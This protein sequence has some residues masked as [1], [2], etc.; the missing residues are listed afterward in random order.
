MIKTV[1]GTIAILL[2]LVATLIACTS[3][4]T[5]T[6][7]EISTPTP[8]P[9]PKP[10]EA[11]SNL[12]A[13]PSTN[14]VNLYWDDN[15]NDEQGFR[16]YRDGSLISTLLS[17]TTTYQ[18]VGL[19]P[20][21]TYQYRVTAFNQTGESGTGIL[22]VRTPNPPITVK[23]DRIGVHDNGEEF[24]RDI[25]GG[26][27]YIGII[28]TDGSK[29]I[30]TRLPTQE[31]QFFNLY[32]D[33]IKDIGTILFSTNEVGDYLRIAAVGYESDGGP[34]E[35]LIYQ[36]LGTAAESYLT[37]GATS[38]LGLDL[39]LGNIIGTLFGAEDDW[40]GSFEKAWD[41]NSDWGIGSYTDVS[42]QMKDGTIGLRFWFTID[43]R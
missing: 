10:P 33:D 18:D 23:I 31:G 28:I 13:T 15:S 25:D 8:A 2:V 42:C 43:S 11:P 22:S 38:L 36:A 4:Q 24:L 1:L 37:G 29:T 9:A 7:R 21:T 20:A 26:E 6:P 17:N 41:L 39:G 40:L 5:Y 16:I 35:T 19:R 34:G 3:P 32:D 12:I 30:K 27:I 14:N